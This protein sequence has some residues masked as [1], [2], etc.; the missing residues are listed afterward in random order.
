MAFDGKFLNP[1]GAQTGRMNIWA[2]G[3]VDDPD[4][5]AY[6]DLITDMDTSGYFDDAVDYGLR[7]GDVLYLRDITTNATGARFVNI[8][9]S[10]VST[11]NLVDK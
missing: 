11:A 5:P 7:I 6:G 8:V 1:V 2:Y 10:V 3:G 4:S 9:G